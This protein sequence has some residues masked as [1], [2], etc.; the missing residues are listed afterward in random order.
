[1]VTARLM[2]SPSLPI[3]L[4]KAASGS[5]TQDILSISVN[6]EGEIFVGNKHIAS[7]N[8]LIAAAKEASKKTTDLRAVLQADGAVR[9]E[10]IVHIM[11]L[12]RQQGI[13]KLAF[14]VNPTPSQNSQ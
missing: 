1:M 13:S 9:H 14:G 12:L 10:R 5:E 6:P 3:D 11:D 8:E 4:P 2:T 7:D